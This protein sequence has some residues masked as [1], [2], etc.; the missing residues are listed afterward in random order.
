MIYIPLAVCV[1]GV[2]MFFNCKQEPWR[3]A[4]KVA[5]FAGLLV[6]LFRCAGGTALLPVRW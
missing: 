2:V 5:F 3:E 6:V 4:G 1:L